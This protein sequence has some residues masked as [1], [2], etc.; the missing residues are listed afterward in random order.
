MAISAITTETVPSMQD[1][2]ATT[3]V[4]GKND[5]LNLLVAQLKNQDP[6]K[7]MDSTEFTA[8]LAQFSSLE[9][10]YNVN[11]N[12]DYLGNNQVA[13]SNNQAV[14]MIGKTAWADGN[15][16]QKTDSETTDIH[17]GLGG[18]ATQTVVNIYNA[19]GNFIKTISVGAK[20]AGN[21]S[22]SWDGTND[23]GGMVPDGAYQFEVLAGDTEGGIIPTETFIVG[24]VSGVT[25]NNGAAQ[26]IVNDLNIPMQ[27][28]VH[29]AETTTTDTDTSTLTF[30]R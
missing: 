11:D 18:S 4:L 7:P 10:L 29:V 12:L 2:H 17:F 5:F 15:I 1:T 23:A 6:L 13:M 26:L 21:H 8:Q 19:Q 28:V 30:F 3:D 9:Q 16:V 27:A 14:S 24:V 22:I 25:F 20:E